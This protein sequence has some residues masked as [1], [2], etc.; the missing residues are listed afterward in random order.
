[1]MTTAD[2]AMRMDPAHEKI[3]RHCQAKPKE[4]ADALARAWCKLTHRGMGPVSRYLGPL[5][6]ATGKLKWTATTVDLVFGSNSQ[7]RAFVE[8]YATVTRSRC[9]CVTSWRPGAR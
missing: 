9:S 7:L 2:M 5:V 3:A 6:K 4:F 8:V 1:M